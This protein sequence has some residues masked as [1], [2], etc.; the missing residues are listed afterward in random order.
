ML[1]NQVKEEVTINFHKLYGENITVD[2]VIKNQINPHKFREDMIENYRVL[3]YK[4]FQSF[5]TNRKYFVALPFWQ[6]LLNDEYVDGYN[7]LAKLEVYDYVRL[8]SVDFF[9]K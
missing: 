7:D 8:W 5:L 1:L 3:F 6:K 9:R 4:G 2:E